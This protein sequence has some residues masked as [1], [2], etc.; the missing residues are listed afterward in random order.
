MIELHVYFTSSNAVPYKL[1]IPAIWD[2]K[3]EYNYFIYNYKIFRCIRFRDVNVDNQ[4]MKPI[5]ILCISW[6]ILDRINWFQLAY[7][8]TF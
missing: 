2:K 3:L 8:T 7:E 1:I 4:Q 6:L 5:F